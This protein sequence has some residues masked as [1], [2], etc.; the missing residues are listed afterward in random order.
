MGNMSTFLAI[1]GMLSAS[2][3]TLTDYVFKMHIRWLDDVNPNPRQE[4]LR[5]M[6]IHLIAGIFGGLLAYT[7]GV[8]PLSYLGCTPPAW[9]TS[10]LGGKAEYFFIAV[11]VSF[12]GS[13]FNEA[14]DLLRQYKLQQEN[15]TKESL[16]GTQ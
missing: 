7:S 16:G 14:L 3:Q 8:H 5:Q 10:W 9:I 2:T 11:M 1:M 12:G 4:A 6:L 13:F 15:I